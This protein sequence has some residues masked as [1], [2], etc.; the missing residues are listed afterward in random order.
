MVNLSKQLLL[1]EFIRK[2]H[3]DNVYELSNN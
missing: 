1:E 2:V 3:I